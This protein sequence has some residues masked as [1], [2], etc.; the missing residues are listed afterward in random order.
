[1]HQLASMLIRL[2]AKMAK[3]EQVGLRLQSQALVVMPL[4]LI[5]SNE[6]ETSLMGLLVERTLLVLANQLIRLLDKFSNLK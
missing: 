5:T 3:E 1:M 6:S 2:E 4:R